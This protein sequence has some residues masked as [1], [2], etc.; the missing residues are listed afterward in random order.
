MTTAFRLAAA[1]AL[2]LA[3]NTGAFA[4]PAGDATKGKTAFTQTC[5]ACHAPDA[6]RVGPMLG[7]VVGRKAG[8][9]AGFNYS[10]AVKNSGITWNED[11]LDQWLSGPGK[12]IPGTRMV[13]TVADAQ[14]RADI[15]AYLKTTAA[16][17]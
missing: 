5:G 12:L 3:F 8:T 11:K 13:M 2:L 1:A 10:D 4:T 6:N 14:K 7:G 15:I 17:K 16:A 9:A